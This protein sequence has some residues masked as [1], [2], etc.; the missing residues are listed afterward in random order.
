MPADQW[1]GE[2]KVKVGSHKIPAQFRKQQPGV[3]Y[4]MVLHY[5]LYVASVVYM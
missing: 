1:K 3:V 4:C 5:I 2:A